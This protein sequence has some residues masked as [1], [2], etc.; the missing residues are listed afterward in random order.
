MGQMTTWA[1]TI[2]DKAGGILTGLSAFGALLISFMNNKKIREV[3]VQINSRMDELLKK[4][5]LLNRAE[6]KA[7]GQAEERN[8]KTD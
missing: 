6:G 1:E 2:I 7:E 3:H 5:G 4:S 8:R